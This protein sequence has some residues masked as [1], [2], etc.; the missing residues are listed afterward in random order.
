MT[1]TLEKPPYGS[2]CNKCGKCCEDQLC[3]LGS[4][5]FNKQDGPCPAL[6]HNAD[7]TGTCGL[8]SDPKKWA[9]FRVAG[10]GEE[11]MRK[12]ALLLIG[13]DSGCDALLK[14]EPINEAF[15]AELRRKAHKH[16]HSSVVALADWGKW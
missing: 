14:G 13:A 2:P 15:R 3:P 8:V 6:E 5:L 9:P 4:L 16:R 7:G 10:N 1:E 11:R 12:S